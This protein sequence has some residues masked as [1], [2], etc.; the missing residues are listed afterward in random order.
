VTGSY[1]TSDDV[2]LSGDQGRSTI[3]ADDLAVAVVDEIEQPTHRRRRFHVA[4]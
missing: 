3:S 2:L 1:R 4:H